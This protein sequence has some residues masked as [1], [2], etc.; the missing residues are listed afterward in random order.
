MKILRPTKGKAIAALET[1]IGATAVA[2]A[3]ING[4]IPAVHAGTTK[5]RARHG[6]GR[7]TAIEKAERQ[8]H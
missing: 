5:A 7:A 1:T 8:S 3:E 6:N 4:M 2:Q